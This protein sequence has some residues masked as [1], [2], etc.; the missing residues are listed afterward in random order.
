MS[1]MQYHSIVILVSGLERAQRHRDKAIELVG[2]AVSPLVECAGYVDNYSFFVAPDVQKEE[3]SESKEFD[4]RRAALRA[5]LEALPQA[6]SPQWVEV[7]WGELGSRVIADDDAPFGRL[8]EQ[9]R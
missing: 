4:Q 1:T 8:S 5:Y 3:R 2:A 9:P 6:D 7:T